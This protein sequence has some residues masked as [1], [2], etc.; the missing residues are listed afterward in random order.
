MMRFD[1]G[2]WAAERG[3]ALYHVGIKRALCQEIDAAD[4]V[5]L[6]LEHIDEQLADH[7]ALDLGVGDP[8][9]RI[10]ELRRGINGDERDVVVAA[11]E[12]D[13]LLRFAFAE[14]T[15][16]HEDAGELVAD[17]LM[18]EKRGNRG[19][20]AAGQTADDVA[21][22]HLLADALD[23]AVAE[24]RYGPVARASGDSV[25]E[26]GEKLRALRGVHH[27][28]VEL[29]AIK[30]PRIVGDGR[31]RRAHRDADGAEARGQPRHAVAMAHPHL[32]PL[33]LLEHALEQ[34]RLVDDLKLGATELAVMPALD[35]PAKR[36]HHGLLAITDAKHRHAGGEKRL[37][38]LRRA[39][40]VHAG[41]PA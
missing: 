41:R 20:D 11:E 13:D 25:D 16:I 35:L 6:R 31:E 19:V 8:L 39:D 34:R 3:S 15:M 33:A 7:L 29:E 1:G 22:S 10:E 36:S 24:M 28:G 9:Q 26:I 4:L 30:P 2:R 14:Q 37:R 21:L 32:R 18:D 12:I 38:R 27:L 23:L 40:L 17:R 5:R